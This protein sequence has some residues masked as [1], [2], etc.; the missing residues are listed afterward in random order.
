[1]IVGTDSTFLQLYGLELAEGQLWQ[2]DFEAV[3]G[4][5]VARKNGLK[6]GDNIYGAHGLSS[7]GHAHDE[8]PYVVT[9]IL[10]PGHH[11]V[12]R[13]IMSNLASVWRMHGDEG[14]E[15]EAEHEHDTTEP[16]D[17]G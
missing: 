12:D 13:L 2:D 6:I 10:K 4:A 15:H 7:E 9:G 11:I 14:H 8:H 17:D 16:D 1:R 5:E 3:I